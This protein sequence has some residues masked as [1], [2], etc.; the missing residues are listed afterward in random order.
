MIA[1]RATTILSYGS[2]DPRDCVLTVRF[3]LHG[4]DLR[5]ES[6]TGEFSYRDQ[7][8]WPLTPPGMTE[9]YRGALRRG[10]AIP[11]VTALEVLSK[12][13]G[14]C[15]Y[16]R[17]FRRAGYITGWLVASALA[18]WLAGTVL[19]GTV[20]KLAAKSM[21]WNGV[22]AALTAGTYAV[23]MPSHEMQLRFE[24]V[25]MPVRLSWCFWLLLAVGGLN[26]GLGAWMLYNERNMPGYFASVF[27]MDF[28]YPVY[29][30]GWPV[31][32][33][34]PAVSSLR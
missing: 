7:L 13:A 15:T 4:A 9:L 12:D 1:G 23:L 8:E 16:G 6:P 33:K 11:L 17:H 28:D 2:S 30:Y 5:L 34:K 29:R 18:V 27:E 3:G 25:V 21:C 31:F 19:L 24:G 26:L 10:L 32:I 20:P 22:L 14:P